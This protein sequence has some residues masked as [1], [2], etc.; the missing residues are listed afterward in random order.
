MSTVDDLTT[1][2]TLDDIRGSIYNVLA[3]TGV[4][5]TVWKPGAVVRTIITAVAIVLAGLSMLISTLARSSFLALAT[6]EWLRLVALY[7]Y[8]V[9]R[10]EA[11]FALGFVTLINVSGGIYDLQPG[12]LTL[13]N[14]ITRKS[15]VNTSHIVLGATSTLTGV[16]IA[17]IEVG[18]ASTSFGD[19]VSNVVTALTGVSC[20]NP[21]PVVGNDVESDPSLRLRCTEKLGS[22]SPNGPPDAYGFVA[23]SATRADG[24][25][26]GV[27][28]VRALP[29]GAGGIDVY[30]ADASGP[31]SGAIGDLTTDLGQIDDQL[32]RL[33]TPLCVACRTH[34]ATAVA[35]PMT[36]AIWLYN[37]SGLT[38]T[39][40][41]DAIAAEVT[42]YFAAVPIGGNRI[43]GLPG[44]VYLTELNAIVGRARANGVQLPIVRVVPTLPAADVTFGNGEIPVL[45]AF[46]LTS[47]QI[48]A[49]GL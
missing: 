16:P 47:T 27:T 38:S 29:D 28:R 13:Q 30:V 5:T 33:A 23:R 36:Y 46:A 45:G 15:Y 9:V 31:I 3:S 39:G 25:L 37:N 6:G 18:S 42:A 26:I 11:T 35:V 14:P 19:E 8:N 7:V 22:L 10:Y 12:D 43:D 41:S 24:S 17:A 40:I 20:T 21:S 48:S 34:S 1:P 44:A 4:T 32:Q 2:L 49:G